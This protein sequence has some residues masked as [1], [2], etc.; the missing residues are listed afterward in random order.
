MDL[1]KGIALLAAPVTAPQEMS[2]AELVRRHNDVP[3]R[4]GSLRLTPESIGFDD[5]DVAWR[6][7]VARRTRPVDAFLTDDVIDHEMQ[8]IRG[9]IVQRGALGRTKEMESSLMVALIL[10]A[11]PG[12][13]RSIEATAAAHEIEVVRG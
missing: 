5:D 2:V 12:V 9:L 8:P 13:H 4:S 7:V 3:N 1:L 10:A 6:K 11:L